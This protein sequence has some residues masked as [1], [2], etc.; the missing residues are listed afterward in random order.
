MR[1]Y[2]RDDETIVINPGPPPNQFAADALKE[3]LQ[4]IEDIKE[5][6]EKE[7]QSEGPYDK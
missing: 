3:A 2:I 5:N 4:E 1:I 7:N 6:A